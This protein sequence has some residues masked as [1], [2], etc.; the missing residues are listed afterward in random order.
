MI[1]NIQ[2]LIELI[3]EENTGTPKMIAEKLDVS[4]RMIYNYI[5]I[6]KTEFKAPVKYDRILKSYYF[7]SK[8]KLD[9]RWQK[10]VE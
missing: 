3:H 5:D 4:E 6:I 9:L 2:K 10:D 7:E 8:G 1:V